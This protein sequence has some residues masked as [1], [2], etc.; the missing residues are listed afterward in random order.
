MSSRAIRL[1]LRQEV[2]AR[3]VRETERDA[4]FSGDVLIALESAW[5]CADSSVPGPTPQ[6]SV[7][8]IG[9]RGLEHAL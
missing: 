1:F 4:L 5:L 3:A 7:I 6:Q 9:S 8:S 2:R